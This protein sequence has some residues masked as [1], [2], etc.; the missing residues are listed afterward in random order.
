MKKKVNYLSYCIY[1]NKP[2]LPLDD[3]RRQDD[4]FFHLYYFYKLSFEK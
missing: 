4:N 1:K 2:F 3:N